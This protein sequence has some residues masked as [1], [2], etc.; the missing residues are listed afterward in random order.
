MK[1]TKVLGFSVI[2]VAAW[3][4]GCSGKSVGSNHGE[5]TG[6]S[7]N[8]GEGGSGNGGGVSPG[9]SDPGGSESGGTGGDAPTGGR[10]T[11]GH[12]PSG[13]VTTGGYLPTGGELTGGVLTG[14]V[15]TG[16]VGLGGN[17]GYG[18]EGGWDDTGGSE[19]TGG[20]GDGG[21]GSGG[22]GAGGSGN[23][24]NSGGSEG[25]W[26]GWIPLGGWGNPGGRG[27]LGG[28]GNPG[29]WGGWQP[30]GDPIPEDWPTDSDYVGA[31]LPA[32]IDDL[33]SAQPGDIFQAYN[34]TKWTTM[35]TGQWLLCPDTAPATTP[36]PDDVV[37]LLFADDGEFVALVLDSSD[38]VVLASGIDYTGEWLYR[39]YYLG[40][41]RL[42]P[43]GAFDPTYNDVI[44]GLDPIQLRAENVGR[45]IRP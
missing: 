27:N 44:L 39:N 13:G 5:A 32:N 16:G 22:D 4:A 14:G 41:L 19:N 33:C 34:T 30:S 40:N 11:G 38:Q 9:G 28:R 35:L 1:A 29:G 42:Q 6:G 26:G 10:V 24:G 7:A 17:A 3:G 36:L 20:G 12:G 8:G 21:W 23:R 43:D 15:L 18:N 37:G 2:V 45:L 25:G 31:P